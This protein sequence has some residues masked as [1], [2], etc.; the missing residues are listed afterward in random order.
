MIAVM[1][2]SYLWSLIDSEDENH[3]KA[4][5]WIKSKVVGELCI[6]PTVMMEFRARYNLEF[7]KLIAGF[8]VRVEN[9]S[10]NKFDL[11]EVNRIVDQEAAK[12]SKQ[13][14]VN[15]QKLNKYRTA[16]HE[17]CRKAF[18]AKSSTKLT[19]RELKE[20]FSSLKDRVE[21][22]TTG[23]LSILTEI[24]YDLPDI[25]GLSINK[26]VKQ[27]LEKNIKFNGTGDSMIAGELICLLTKDGGNHYQFVTFDENFT[28][29][30]NFA[31]SELN[32]GN[33]DIMRI[34]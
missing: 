16:L 9:D 12:L 17:S 32:I 14:T 8:L 26:M 27:I 23:T 13:R 1:D 34:G 33:V 5:K 25:E 18:R 4:V 28:K 10:Q 15:T 30:F 29:L 22:K 2:T 7:N 3:D 19:K 21:S 24:G 11:S 6:L 31:C 20:E